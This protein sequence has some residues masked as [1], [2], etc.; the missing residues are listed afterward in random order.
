MPYKD[1]DKKLEA[2]RRWRREVMPKGYGKWLYA[3][4]KLRFDDA[5]RFRGA[6]GDSIEHL[7]VALGSDDMEDVQDA[8]EQALHELQEALRESMEAEQELGEFD[9]G[10]E[11]S[12]E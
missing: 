3:R 9:F 12:N 6:I 5:E 4:R 7:L 10:E 2:M 1:P 11:V 8:A